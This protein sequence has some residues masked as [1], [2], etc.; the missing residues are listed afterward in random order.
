MAIGKTN[1]AGG[2]GLNFAVKRYDTE[3]DML[4]TTPKENTV[5]VISTVEMTDWIIDANQPENPTEGMIWISVG[6]QSAVEFNA[7]KKNGI[8]I[9]PMSA[10]QHVGGAWVN[11]TTKSY[12][13]G[14][15]SDWWNGELYT[16]GEQ[17]E[18]VTGGWSNVGYNRDG[19]SDNVS[20]ATL[21]STGIKFDSS[22]SGGSFSAAGTQKKIDL[23]EYNY[24]EVNGTLTSKNGNYGLVIRVLTSKNFYP[25]PA[26]MATCNTVGDFSIKIPL[27]GLN[28]EYY[29]LIATDGITGIVGEVNEVRLT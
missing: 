23:S 27:T 6:T 18:T 16:P 25:T 24:L 26:A 11:K 12:Q 22:N 5:G 10:K 14:V 13:S 28:D 9:Y 29:I 2:A 21:S 20:M 15:W 1:A 3:M 8:M 17:Y 4:A 7:L 19:V